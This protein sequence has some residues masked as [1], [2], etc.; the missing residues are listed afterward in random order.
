MRVAP[1]SPVSLNGVC[2]YF[3]AIIKL[4][5]TPKGVQRVAAIFPGSL[6]STISIH[7]T[8][9]GSGSLFFIFMNVQLSSVSLVSAYSGET[10]LIL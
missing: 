4:S 2:S 3:V 9:C 8:G 7:L 10:T 1:M 6:S 5:W